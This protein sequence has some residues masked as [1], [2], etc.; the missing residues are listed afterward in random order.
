MA[1]ERNSYWDT[2]KTLL[3]FLVVLGHTG[4]ALGDN[5]LSVIYSFHMP[6][7]MLV[8]GFFTKKKSIEKFR[9]GVC[10]LLIIYLIFHSAYLLFDYAIGVNISFRRILTPSFALWYILVLIYYRSFI[11]FMPQRIL[12]NAALILIGSILI[13]LIS[14]YVPIQDQ[15]SFQRACVFF[16][17]FVAGYYINRYDLLSRIRSNNKLIAAFVLVCLIVLNYFYL[18]VF[19]ASNLYGSSNGII[20]RAIQIGVAVIMCLSIIIIIPDSIGRF[21]DIGKYTLLI[22]LIHPPIIKIAK[23][24]CKLA[25]YEMGIVGAIVLSVLTIYLI[26]I[27]RNIKIFRYLK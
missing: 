5:V 2:I 10:K 13:A 17:F 4:T 12:D 11:Q 14:G 1:N 15:M 20:M 6:L 22:Y 23:E 24:L 18:P 7:F 26:Y 16:P 19:Y 25:G 27:V 9:G 8:S 21:T 3:I